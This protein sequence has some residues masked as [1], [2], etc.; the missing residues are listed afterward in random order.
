MGPAI[1]NPA[2]VKDA[3]QKRFIEPVVEIQRT[4]AGHTSKLDRLD[5]L[6]TDEV[7]AQTS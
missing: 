6:A 7:K 2:I 4:A 3:V 5:T 1:D